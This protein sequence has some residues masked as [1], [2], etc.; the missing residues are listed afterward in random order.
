M[1]HKKESALPYAQKALDG[2]YNF[3]LK[4]K[5]VFRPKTAKK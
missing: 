2:L 1:T 4:K 5:M 3:A